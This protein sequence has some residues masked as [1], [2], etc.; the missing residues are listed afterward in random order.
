MKGLVTTF[1]LVL[2]V[3]APNM[4]SAMVYLNGSPYLATTSPDDFMMQGGNIPGGSVW[5]AQNDAQTRAQ[6]YCTYSQRN[7]QLVNFRI[8]GQTS[9]FFVTIGYGWSV[10]QVPYN[11]V[12]PFNQQGLTG[13]ARGFDSIRCR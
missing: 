12:Q 6:Q 9:N 8:S 3:L 1:A 2:A 13:Y 7:S 11:L 5:Q 4:A 10:Q